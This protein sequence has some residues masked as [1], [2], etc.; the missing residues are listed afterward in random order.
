MC[1][2]PT[3]GLLVVNGVLWTAIGTKI[4]VTGVAS[5]IRLGA[6]VAA[7]AAAARYNR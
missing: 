2:I 5:Y 4:L 6:A 3:K 7:A 1:K